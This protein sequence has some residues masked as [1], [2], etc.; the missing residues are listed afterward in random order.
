MKELIAILKEKCSNTANN[1]IADD[2]SLLPDFP[3]STTEEFFEFN[4]RLKNDE[5]IH[6]RFKQAIMQI[7]GD[8]N[9][10][11]VSNILSHTMAY[12][13]GHKMSWIGAKGSIAI[14]NSSFINIVV[15]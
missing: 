9:Q 2:L 15:E 5:A 1:E 3:L 11:I 10:K 12:E 4:N 6:K 7:G 14:K 13:L 8:T